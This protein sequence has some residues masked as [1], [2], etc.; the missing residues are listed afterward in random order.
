MKILFYLK[1]DDQKINKKILKNWKKK[2]FFT[3]IFFYN[4]LRHFRFF[5]RFALPNSFSGRP[6]FVYHNK[7]PPNSSWSKWYW[8]ALPSMPGHVPIW[9]N[10]VV[11]GPILNISNS[12]CI[13]N[14]NLA[15]SDTVQ[16]CSDLANPLPS[17]L[18]RL[19]W[20]IARDHCTG[21][22]LAI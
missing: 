1:M 2:I 9:P 11:Y 19:A 15:F 16:L 13:S 3:S 18:L 4:F 17:A 12:M 21:V 10:F 22:C 8:W 7:N 14:G 5:G 20:A 6:Y